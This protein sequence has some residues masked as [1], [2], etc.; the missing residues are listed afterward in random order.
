MNVVFKE[1]LPDQPDLGNEG[2]TVATNVIPAYGSYAPFS[3]LD[4]VLVGS[5]TLPGIARGA[6]AFQQGLSGAQNYY[7]AA[8][9]SGIYQ[10]FIGIG[11]GTFNSV[12]TGL[13]T[14]NS[15]TRVQ[16]AQFDDFLFAARGLDGIQ[17]HT[18]GSA[19]NF[20][21][22]S[23]LTGLRDGRYVFVVNRFLVVAN[24]G[25]ATA[26]PSTLEWSAIDDPTNFPTPNSATAI[27]TQSGEQILNAADGEILGGFGG[28]QYAIIVQRGAIVRMTYVGPPVV[29]Q[30]DRL[31]VNKGAARRYANAAV[32]SNAYFVSADGIYRT[33][34]VSS[35]NIG[36][37]R[38]NKTFI[39][40]DAGDVG[41]G[42]ITAYAQPEAAFDT[43]TN[44]IVI[45]TPVNAVT[46]NSSRAWFYSVDQNKWSL[47]N[48]EMR[49]PFPSGPGSTSDG[50][51]AF[52][53]ANVL[54]KFSGTAGTAILTTGEVELNEAG[55]AHLSGVKPHIESTGTAPTVTVRVGYRDVLSSA[56]T[57]TATASAFSRTGIANFRVDAKYHRAEVQIVG[58]F[59]KATGLEFQAVPTGLA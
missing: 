31:E 1:W 44:C 59:A 17:K 19:T 28:D 16:F 11:G 33:D 39:A 12:S 29:F 25:S 32:G 43:K 23:G 8:T 5:Y 18:I 14:I 38:V 27:A 35:E 40:S 34:G 4:P 45:A 26:R 15:R 21:T 47:C 42:V 10:A 56:P 41:A 48:Q 36:A 9:D 46:M 37:G 52:N 57:Y 13:S 51:L 3:P 22:V 7:Y 6:Y 50:L 53:S 2:L 55:R 54:C 49:C 58:N 20:S 24:L 30:F